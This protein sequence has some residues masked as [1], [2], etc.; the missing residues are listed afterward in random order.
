MNT[1]MK[2][3]YLFLP[4]LWAALFLAACGDSSAGDEPGP[5]PDPGPGP[6]PGPG[7]APAPFVITVSDQTTWTADIVWTPQTDDQAYVA[8]IVDKASFD[9]FA[10]DEAY[11]AGDIEYFRQLAEYFET[12]FETIHAKYTVTGPSTQQAVGLKSDTEYYAYAFGLA[13]DGTAT[14]GLVKTAFKTTVVQ[15]VDCRFD[16]TATEVG[17]TTARVYI[18]P[19]D[20]TCSY[21]WDC[22]SREEYDK[23]GDPASVIATNID[24]IERAVEIF[25][26]AGIDRTFADFLNSDVGYSDL[27]ELKGDTEY[28]VF[29]FGLDPSGAATTTVT[30]KSFRTAPAS[31]SSM[32]FTTELLSLN[33]NGARVAFTPSNNSETYFTD[34]VDLET[35]SEYASDAQFMQDIV[36][37]AGASM[38]SFLTSGY[39][40]VDASRMLVSQT[41]YVAYA[42]GYSGGITTGMAKEEFTTP[43]MPS[44]GKA[45]V[46]ITPLIENGDSYYDRDEIIYADYKGKAVV[47]F[48]LTPSGDAAH[49]YIAAF[50]SSISGYE[51]LLLA[52]ML[53]TAGYEDR[54]KI[55][56]LAAWGSEIPVAAVATDSD[57]KAGAVKRL[58]VQVEKSAV[59]AAA[60]HSPVKL[61]APLELPAPAASSKASTPPTAAKAVTTLRQQYRDEMPKL[62]AARSMTA[63]LQQRRFLQ[64]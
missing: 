4:L 51:D 1:A 11:I 43:A 62:G 25:Q 2:Y 29:A 54:Q 5:G 61:F 52:E 56:L 48:T 37:Q 60:P 20:K 21:F 26:M 45:T 10:T 22:V 42:F 7:P 13:S 31:S 18:T 9:E 39:H 38:S 50:K 16:I 14:S 15:P 12:D 6:G 55:G 30:E 19:T 8:M 64:R 53:Q 41:R 57:G 27:T 23:F 63:P 46:E 58:S 47:Q 35:Y 3:S 49:W 59:A 32:T 28:V 34:C 44:G 36:S 40:V 17:T 33:F 24:L